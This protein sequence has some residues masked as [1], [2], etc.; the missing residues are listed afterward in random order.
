MSIPYDCETPESAICAPISYRV[1]IDSTLVLPVFIVYARY[2]GNALSLHPG[3]EQTFQAQNTDFC[4]AMA[5]IS[6]AATL[7]YST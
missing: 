3:V 2:R 1:S 6:T 7:F 5:A 4:A